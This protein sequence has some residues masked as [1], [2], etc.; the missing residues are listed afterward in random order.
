MH[1]IKISSSPHPDPSLKNLPVNLSPPP[2]YHS[3]PT[4]SLPPLLLAY[5]PLPEFANFAS[6]SA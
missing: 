4:N 2:V 6:F 1:N 5:S 3:I